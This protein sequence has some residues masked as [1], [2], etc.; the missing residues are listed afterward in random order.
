MRSWR[1]TCRSRP[2]FFG[3]RP[4]HKEYI[5]EEIFTLVRHCKI[6]YD[7]AWDMPVEI[8]HWWIEREN[9][10]RKK[11]EQEIKGDEHTD[12]FGRVHNK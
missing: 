12:A 11:E 10:E 7:Q 9:K 2:S 8:R 1:S 3:L 5:Y 6:G 4:D